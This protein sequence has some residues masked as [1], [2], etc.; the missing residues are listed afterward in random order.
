MAVRA[1]STVAGAPPS[2]TRQAPLAVLVDALSIPPAASGIRVYLQQ[3]L[4]RLQHEARIHVVC[5]RANVGLFAGLD[6]AG[7]TVVPLAHRGRG[8]RVLV[9]Q[10]VV[11]LVIR[12]V[13]P[14]LVFAPVDVAP[15]LSGRPVVTCVHSSHINVHLGYARGLH[16]WYLMTFM[17]LSVRRSFR[18]I[19]ISEYVRDM[20]VRLLDAAPARIDVVY[21][22]LGLAETTGVDAGA[23]DAARTGG[24][25]FL[26]TLH[27]HKRVDRLIEAYA[28]LRQR[29]PEAPRLLIAGHD[30]HRQTPRLL[31]LARR[32]GVAGETDF[33][34]RVPDERVVEL[35][36]SSRLMVYPSESEGFGLPVLEA[37]G[38]G[39]PVVASNRA[40]IPEVVGDAGIVVDPDDV[41]ALA[42]AMHRV[43]AD[44]EL[45]SRLVVAGRERVRHFSWDRTARETLRV[46][47]AAAGPRAAA[48][49]I[50]P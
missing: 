38:A 22:G 42:D 26:S 21:H 7:R 18:V 30:P 16:A 50:G 1:L 33:L 3:L 12:R 17:R 49:S 29:D 4:E 2:A 43:L 34:G 35:L 11:P 40:S 27:P 20:T 10:L 15:L 28:V 13:R 36:R 45:R 25:L 41:G 6:L 8:P 44:P 48:N 32:L 31:E 47:Q 5:T 9:Q 46:W 24:I 23:A 14:D 39:I 37:M 19:A